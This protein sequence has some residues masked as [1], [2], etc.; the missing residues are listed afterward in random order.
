MSGRL[1]RAGASL[2]LLRYAVRG[3]NQRVAAPPSP[4]PDARWAL[5]EVR[6]ELGDV[7]V[8]LLGHSMGDPAHPDFMCVQHACRSIVP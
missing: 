3:W 8:V 2:W 6:S 4:V 1:N 5:D 7:P